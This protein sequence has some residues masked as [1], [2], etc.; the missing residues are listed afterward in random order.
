MDCKFAIDL[1]KY[2]VDCTLFL[3]PESSHYLLG[4][5]NSSAVNW[6]FKQISP[7]IQGGFIRFKSIYVSQIPVPKSISVVEKQI[8]VF[9]K[10]IGNASSQPHA[11][12][13]VRFLESIINAIVYELYLPDI[14]HAAERYPAKVISEAGVPELKGKDAADLERIR[15]YVRRLSAPDHAVAQL[16]YYLDSIPEIRIIEG[17]TGA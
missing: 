10:S 15:N 14:L 6:F 7:S 4:V 9:T 17:K 8:E 11:Q 16:L 3:I 13:E 1:E 2:Y 12:V 5:L